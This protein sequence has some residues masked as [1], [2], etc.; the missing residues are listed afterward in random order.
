MMDN[1]SQ[2]SWPRILIVGNLGYIGPVLTRFLK[3]SVPQ[4]HL[5]GLDTGYFSGCLIDPYATYEHFLDRQ[6][7]RD[8]R[9]IDASDFPKADVVVYLAAISNDPMGN[10][11]EVPTQQINTAAAV[12]LA[13]LAKES[14][15][16]SFVFASSCS[17]YGAGGEVPKKEGDNLQPLTAYAR[18]KI[19][20]EHALRPLAGPEFLVTCLRFATACGASPRL[21][22]DLVLNDFVASA[23]LRKEIEVLS[24]GM[25]WRPLIDVEDM[26]R[27]IGWAADRDASAG[28][29]FLALNVGFD[30]WNFRIRDLAVAVSDQ[31]KGVDVRINPH[32]VPDKRS[33]RVDFSLYRSLCPQNMNSKTLTRTILELVE[34]IER[35]GFRA[36]DFRQ[37]HLIRLNTLNRLR[38][39]NRLDELLYWRD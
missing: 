21:R 33:Y 8:V 2:S 10:V 1:S 16:R 20:S 15:A 32:A 37:S 24:D 36:E 29:A 12:N 6:I 26:C 39:G 31:I 11:Y 34:T 38:G 25:P 7:Y 22:L 5:V 23:L 27:A 3:A 4:S 28:G 18:S 17:V 14:G 19:D 30:D 9:R 13:R 35:S